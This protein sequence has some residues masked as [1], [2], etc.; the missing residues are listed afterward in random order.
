MSL[1]LEKRIY[2]L[3]PLVDVLLQKKEVHGDGVYQQV[4]EQKLRQLFGSEDY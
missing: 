3:L 2:F 1:G 4:K